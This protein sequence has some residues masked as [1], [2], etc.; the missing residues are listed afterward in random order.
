MKPPRQKESEPTWAECSTMEEW[1][2]QMIRQGYEAIVKNMM[3][4]LPEASK[5]KYRLIWTRVKAEMREK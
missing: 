4:V 5:E 1:V 2:E 3:N